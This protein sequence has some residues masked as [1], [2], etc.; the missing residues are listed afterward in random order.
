M[1]QSLR[2]TIMTVSVLGVAVAG[3]AIGRYTAPVSEEA[4]VIEIEALAVT[5]NNRDQIAR[6]E[7]LAKKLSDAESKIQ[8]LNAEIDKILGNDLPP[9][10]PVAE[11][12]TDENP[13]ERAER[14]PRESR[15]AEMERLKTEDPEKYAERV[16][17]QEERAKRREAFVEQRRNS[18]AKRDEFFANV[19]IAY[20]SP[21]EQKS[22]ESFVGEYQE[23]RSL[24]EQQGTGENTDRAKAW[25]LGMSV[26]GKSNTIRAS[27]LKATAKEMGFNET[28]SVEF[29]ESINQIFGATSLMGPGGIDM[30]NM[31]GRGGNSGGRGR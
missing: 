23:L 29:S 31:R 6:N 26:M 22:L 28:E 30:H 20:M 25:Q 17:E 10:E 14:E 5:H 1:K 15:E 11:I 7:L 19:N 13:R 27:L 2:C 8:E 18:E 12:T 9:V 24:M 4:D 3:F 16:K 21:E